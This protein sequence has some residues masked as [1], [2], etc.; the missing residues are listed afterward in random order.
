LPTICQPFTSKLGLK[1]RTEWREYIKAAKKLNNIPSKPESVYKNKG[2][3][4]WADF[5][6]KEK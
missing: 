5:L 4:G 1:N 2:W 3:K 6:G